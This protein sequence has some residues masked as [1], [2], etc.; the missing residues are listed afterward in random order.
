MKIVLIVL[1]AVAVSSCGKSSSAKKSPNEGINT[2]IKIEEIV[3]N[4]SYPAPGQLSFEGELIADFT[5]PGSTSSSFGAVTRGQTLNIIT[6]NTIEFLVYGED[7]VFAVECEP[8]IDYPGHGPTNPKCQV[9]GA[10]SYNSIIIC[11]STVAST[12]IMQ[13]QNWPSYPLAMEDAS[14]GMQCWVDGVKMLS[15][16]IFTY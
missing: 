8:N 9:A 2:A 4:I 11:H 7:G 5:N 14:L 13:A 6:I 3:S 12:P 10:E 16:R 15:N 1:F